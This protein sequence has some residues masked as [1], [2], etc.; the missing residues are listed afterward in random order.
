MKNLLVIF[1]RYLHPDGPR[2]R[3]AGVVTR[4]VA[5][6]QGVPHGS[7]Q[8]AVVVLKRVAGHLRPHILLHRR[9]RWKKTCPETWDICGGHVDADE[10]IL[11]RP[12]EWDDR[13]F[14][15]RLFLETAIREANEELHILSRSDFRF[16]ARHLKCF[17]GPGAFESGFGD[18]NAANR[19][20]SALYAAFVAT[21]VAVVEEA[22]DVKQVFQV[23]DS[24]GVG[25]EERE[26]AALDLKLG[27][28][29]DLVLDFTNHPGDY[30]DGIARVLSRAASEPGTMEALTRFLE[31]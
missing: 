10:Q 20:Y 6:Y 13:D 24:V 26:T 31:S 3:I 8:V 23:I 11:T 1:E 9:S 15:E 5:H 22:D 30:A 14:I 21:D 4:A 17:G 18:P 25:G 7:V 27:S 12:E 29:P 16:E 2:L 19:E 28:L